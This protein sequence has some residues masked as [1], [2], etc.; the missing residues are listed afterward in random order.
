MQESPEDRILRERIEN[1][2]RPLRKELEAFDDRLKEL[3]NVQT[4]ENEA[5]IKQI[6]KNKHV[7]R[8]C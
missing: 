7:Y 3:E 5:L 2:L 8:I 1:V 6:L 4:E